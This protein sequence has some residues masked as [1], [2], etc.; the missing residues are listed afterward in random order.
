[1]DAQKQARANE[2]MQELAELFASAENPDGSWKTFDQME[3]DAN[4]VGD[5][6]EQSESVFGFAKQNHAGIGSNSLIGALE[7]NRAIELRLK[8]VTLV[9]THR[10]ILRSVCVWL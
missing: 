10:V 2:L 4:E 6:V 7:L 8:K 9:F 3:L 5:Q 1:M